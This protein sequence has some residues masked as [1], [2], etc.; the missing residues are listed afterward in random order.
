MGGLQ[1]W[2][3]L[4][5]ASGYLGGIAL[6][7]LCGVV[8]SGIWAF[9]SRLF[10]GE[11]TRFGRHLFILGCG[12]TAIVLVDYVYEI[13]AY[14]LSLEVITRYSSHFDIA[15][16]FI[17][18]FFHLQ[19]ISP[20]N[21]RRLSIICIA[22]S[23]LGSATILLYNYRSDKILADELTMKIRFPS[24]IR[25]S[26]DRPISKLLDNAKLLKTKLDKENV[27]N[28]EDD[29]EEDEKAAD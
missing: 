6:A 10:V 19:Q 23:L 21:F 9:A 15:L 14:S 22:L 25:I 8:W 4:F 3:E 16:V 27:A 2:L 12:L 20:N 13:I 5:E 17:I 26:A 18:I 1:P 7:L 24:S 29:G 28:N 11:Q